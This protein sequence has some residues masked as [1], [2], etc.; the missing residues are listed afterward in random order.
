M[1]LLEY[2]KFPGRELGMDTIIQDIAFI[3]IEQNIPAGI[4]ENKRGKQATAL[5]LSILL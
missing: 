2:T 3:R 5:N 1:I 4:P